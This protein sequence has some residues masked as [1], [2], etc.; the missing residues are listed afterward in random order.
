MSSDNDNNNVNST[1]NAVTG[2]VEA[3]PVY[4][5]AIQPA[6]KEIGKALGTLAKTVNVALAPV[7]ALVWGYDKIKDF[8]DHKVSAKLENTPAENIVTPPA[9][10]VGPA[11]ESLRYTGSIEELRDLYANL[12]AASMDSRTTENAHP[13]FVEIIKQLST[14]EA[15][16]LSQL[17]E[18]G[19]E[20]LVTIRNNRADGSGGQDQF[21]HFS[22][23]GDRAGIDSNKLPNH[24]DNLTR[25]G[26]IEIPENYVLIGEVYKELE[27]HPFTKAVIDYVDALPE[28]KSRI[29]RKTLI[30]TSLG[31]QFIDTC[32]KEHNVD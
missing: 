5:D 17:Q 13:S 24:F 23:L 12:V 18:I 22:L 4:E 3:V 32:V 26:L 10:V 7:S 9:H 2:L 8:V 27:E 6:A 16:L 30:V 25:L 31:R 29:D 14:E 11:L 21:R 1:I 28:R 20:P 15:K 19:S